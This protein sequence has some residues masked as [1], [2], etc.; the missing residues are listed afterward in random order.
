MINS[1][2][3][4]QLSYRGTAS[5]AVRI[6]KLFRFAKPPRQGKCE[7]GAKRPGRVDIR[8]LTV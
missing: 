6:T 8:R 1:H 2:L 7:R 3:L 4:Y 5:V